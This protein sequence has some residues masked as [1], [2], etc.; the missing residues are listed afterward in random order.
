MSRAETTSASLYHRSVVWLL[1]LI[2]LLPDLNAPLIITAMIINGYAAGTMLSVYRVGSGKIVL[3]TLNIL[4][5]VDK[6]PA[7][8]RLLLNMIA[9]AARNAAEPSR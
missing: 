6:H 9:H 1:F 3:N 5:N 7:A 4:D 2:L 8:D